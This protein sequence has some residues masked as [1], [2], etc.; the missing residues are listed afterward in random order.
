MFG[1]R[2]I[3]MVC[4]WAACFDKPAKLLMVAAQ[5]DVPDDPEAPATP[6]VVVEE[7]SS[8]AVE[9]KKDEAGEA[10]EAGDEASNEEKAQQ[11]MDSAQDLQDK[12]A[13]LNELLEAK[14]DT[15]DP[16][17]KERIM[18]LKNQLGSLGVDMGGS[19]VG[20]NQQLTEFYALCISNTVSRVGRKS[21]TINTLA[22]I[23]DPSFTREAAAKSDFWRM[24]IACIQEANEQDL[25]EMKAG[26]MK[27]LPKEFVDIAQSPE[28]EKKVL[29]LGEQ[30]W[31]ELKALV[32]ELVK[33]YRGGNG[34]NSP[35]PN[36]YGLLAF[37]PF[38]G[39]AGLMAKLY[40]DM[41]KKQDEGAKRKAEKDSKKDKKSK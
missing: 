8:E 23:T 13:Q 34:D 29:E 17:L 41:K 14:G 37:I 30:E 36:F 2:G 20:Q 21:G 25:E 35:P 15:I 6:D 4:L 1:Y 26:T 33:A 9:E 5:S 12:L 38:L 24:A 18:G 32:P 10:G 28:G 19:S 3:A 22:K 27:K 39:M 7:A 11:F 31:A 16:E 40:F